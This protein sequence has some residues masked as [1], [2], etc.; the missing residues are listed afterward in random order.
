MTGLRS[1][2]LSM[3]VLAATVIGCGSSGGGGQPGNGGQ[4]GKAGSAG[5]GA[6]GSAGFGG[7]APGGSAGG[8]ATGGA[9][10]G[11]GGGGTSGLCVVAPGLGPNA[12]KITMK[13][14]GMP[15]GFWSGGAGTYEITDPGSATLFHISMQISSDTTSSY[16][17]ITANLP[18]GMTSGTVA[19]GVSVNGEYPLAIT[20]RDGC[21]HVH[22]WSGLAS[23]CSLTFTQ[24]PMTGQAGQAV[25]TF[26]AT[27]GSVA[28]TEGVINV[29]VTPQTLN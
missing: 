26:S 4:G 9:S 6:V 14:N 5:G 16:V 2:L 23:P 28:I 21:D 10:G 18:P 19:C 15:T 25:G 27:M 1:A 22:D 3:V 11:P 12:D 20:Y 8:G 17:I 29:D 24:L 7:G 13:V